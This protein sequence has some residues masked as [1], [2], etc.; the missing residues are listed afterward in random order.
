MKVN[1]NPSTSPSAPY[2]PRMVDEPAVT[3]DLEALVQRPFVKSLMDRVMA[4]QENEYGGVLKVDWQ[5]GTYYTGVFAAYLATR[6]PGFREAAIRWGEAAGWKIGP[7]PFYADDLCMGQTMLDLYL[8]DP[9][10]GYVKDL[11]SVLESYFDKEILTADDVHSHHGENGTRPMRGRSLWWWCDAL[12]MAPP[13]LARMHAATGEQRYLDLLHELYW[14]S[15]KFL[16][17]EKSCLFFRDVDFFPADRE[18]ATESEKRFWS[19]GNGWVYAGLVRV[20]DYLPESDPQRARYLELF[21]KLTRKLVTLQKPDGLW[22]SWL[23]RPDVHQSPEVSGSCFFAYGLLGGVR[24]GWLDSKS[25]LPL[26]LRAWRGLTSKLGTDGRLGFAQLVDSA[27]GPVRPESSIDYTHGAFLLVASELYTLNLSLADLLALEPARQPKLMMENVSWTGLKS[28][29]AVIADDH[30]YLGGVNGSGDVTFHAYRVDPANAASIIQ[31][32]HCLGDGV[33]CDDRMHPA[34]LRFDDQLL[35]VYPDA[36]GETSWNWCR[37]S[38]PNRPPHWGRMSVQ[39]SEPKRFSG[40][41]PADGGSSLA[42][43][44]AEK[45]RIFHFFGS[46][47]TWSDDGAKTWRE[48]VSLIAGKS[49]SWRVKCADNGHD[50]IDLLL[51]DGREIRHLIYQNGGFHTSAGKA[52]RPLELVLQNP[53]RWNKATLIHSS[54]GAIVIEDVGYDS[55]QLPIMVFRTTGSNGSWEYWIANWDDKTSTWDS[56]RLAFAGCGHHDPGFAGGVTLDPEMEGLVYLSTNVDPSTGSPNA[57]GRFQLFRGNLG[58]ESAWEQLTFDANRDNVRPFVPHGHGQRTCV[59][60]LRGT[61][62]SHSDY[63]M[64]IYGILDAG[65]AKRVGQSVSG[66]HEVDESDSP[67]GD[68]DDAEVKPQVASRFREAV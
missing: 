36:R 52:L 24:R 18:T 34:L 41:S 45:C 23:N 62:R 6:E 37:A 15:C 27:P 38:I 53:I 28:G 49:Q 20:L 1:S 57:T 58:D 35:A 51:T 31:E 32:T 48:A 19:R 50:R 44:T 67:Q 10:P 60:W 54:D 55:N 13:V 42:R 61:H 68:Y 11:I 33:T 63:Q 22:S 9:D 14:D 12:Y 43:L 4:F 5:A 40:E 39:W 56:T 64:D 46:E 17:D 8:D 26:A 25:Y 2:A 66:I 30:I 3:A 21:Q 7:R 16:F 59:L 29:R 47:F 65:S